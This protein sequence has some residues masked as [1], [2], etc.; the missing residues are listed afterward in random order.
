MRYSRLTGRMGAR[1]LVVDDDPSIRDVLATAL[2]YAGFDTAMAADGREALAAVNGTAPDLVV[3]DILMPGLDGLEVCRRLRAGEH[4][5]PVIFL[6]ARTTSRDVL[7]GFIAGGDDYMSKPFV[8][9]E[10][11]ARIRAVLHRS[12]RLGGA[13]PLRC[14]DLELDDERHEVRRGGQ[15]ID[16]PPIEFNLLR[17]LL[18]NAGR[19]VSKDQIL[20]RVWHYDYTGDGH[21]VEAAISNL[22]RRLESRGEAR[23]IH[24]I[25]GVGYTLRATE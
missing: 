4:T 25:R 7:D 6:T 3:L 10:L 24:T 8:L 1:V 13:L 17:Y 15:R 5:V 14:S 18:D 12:G 21:V 11:V 9:D 23:L 22:R 16:L 20:G 19:V 2:R